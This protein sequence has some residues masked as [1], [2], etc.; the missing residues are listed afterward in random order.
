MTR[1]G[2]VVMVDIP[3]VESGE[4]DGTCW[5]IAHATENEQENGE[6]QGNIKGTE[7]RSPLGRVKVQLFDSKQTLVGETTTSYDGFYMFDRLIPGQYSIN[8]EPTQLQSL[9]QKTQPAISVTL[10]GNGEVASGMDFELSQ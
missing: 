3:I 6:V 5:L 2:K 7:K 4:I 10:G 1:P 9:G 8:L